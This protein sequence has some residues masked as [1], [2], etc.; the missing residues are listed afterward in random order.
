MAV[1]TPA[2]FPTPTVDASAAATAW[3][4]VTLPAP[5]VRS[6][7]FPSTSPSAV[8]ICRNWTPPVTKSSKTP[9]PM[10][11]TIIGGP[12]TIPFSQSLAFVK[13]SSMRRRCRRW[14]DQ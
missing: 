2:M 3:N 6:R 5:A 10:S 12:H 8:P 9:V 14:D 1:A 11:S 7:S 13:V 4:G